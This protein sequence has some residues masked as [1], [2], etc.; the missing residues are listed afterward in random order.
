MAESEARRSQ[1]DRMILLALNQD[2]R[3]FCDQRE[4][5]YIRIPIGD[6]YRTLRVRS[7]F[8]KSWL[9]GLLW[10]A[11]EKAPGSEAI[12]SALNVLKA[13]CYES[14]VIPLYNRVA[15]NPAGDGLYIDMTDDSWR[16]IQVTKENWR[17]DWHPPILF[18]RYSHQKALPE[19]VRGGS[20]AHLL[21]FTN[22]RNEAERL[23][24]TVTVITSFIPNIPHI[25]MVLY[26]PQGSGKTWTLR[27]ARRVVDPSILDVL[28]LPRRQRELVQNLDHHYCAFYDNVGRIPSWVS[29]VLC[30]AV[31]GSGVS[32]RRLYSD[33]DDV[34]YEYHR[35][36]G[37]TDISVAAE[38][39]DLL[40]RS[41]L[42]GL[43]AIS[44]V[45]RRTEEEMRIM[46]EES[47]PSILGGILDV[48]VKAQKIYP[49]VEL[50]ELFRMADYTKWGYA[51]TEAMGLDPEDFIK[52]YRDN[53][54]LQYLEAVRASP[55]A[56]VLITFMEL[57]TDGT[58]EGTVSQLWTALQNMASQL[59]ISTK[60]KA[61][62]KNSKILSRRL[63]ELSPSLP[64]IGIEL[65]RGYRGK[66]RIIS[67]NVSGDV[68]IDG[69]TDDTDDTAH[70]RGSFSKDETQPLQDGPN[71]PPDAT[72]ICADCN[73][74]ITNG[75][76]ILWK[77]RDR[78]C[79]RCAG[80][81]KK[82][83]ER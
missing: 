34:I 29:N 1:A 22:I 26:G 14:P 49:Q 35:C 66:S 46:L 67:I 56:D 15:T 50:H 42:L 48:L 47:A 73:Q 60:Q 69:A 58:W 23:L 33:D 21:D 61:W 10:A 54:N 71:Y 39:G 12:Q 8:V 7:G 57:M 41:I 79:T 82:M 74:P 59:K 9:A 77:G 55:I 64:A 5:P 52:A 43:D 24:F 32:K 13:K 70:I 27:A 2:I 44:K 80:F 25:V 3:L 62:P 4:D 72:G 16:A 20:A 11:E 6:H 81:R 76:T 75:S 18:R 78:L 30:R 65:N 53:V 51:V 37:L 28:T 17:V 31:T 40:E 19:P 38:R 63:N 45:D 68:G 36:C 83:R